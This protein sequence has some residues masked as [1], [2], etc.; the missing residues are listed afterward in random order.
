MEAQS[1]NRE[2][3]Y[4]TLW[5]MAHNR[6][7]EILHS[8]ASMAQDERARQLENYAAELKSAREIASKPA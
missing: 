4:R 5:L 8:E 7:H 2:S 6:L 1:R 3:E